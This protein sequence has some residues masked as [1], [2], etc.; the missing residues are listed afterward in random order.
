MEMNGQGYWGYDEECEGKG[1]GYGES[2]RM[3]WERREHIY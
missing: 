1:Q 2:E 3:K